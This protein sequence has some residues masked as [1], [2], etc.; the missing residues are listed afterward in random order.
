MAGPGA[1]DGPAGGTGPRGGR[2]D[3]PPV[4]FL[5]GPT[6]SGKSAL[7]L[8]LAEA[9][10]SEIVS[11]DSAQAYRGMDIGT[12]KPSLAERARVAHHLIDVVE[13]DDP[14]SA[15]RFVRDALARIGQIRARG[16]RPLLVGGTMLYFNALQHGLAPMPAADFALRAELAAEL[17]A[18][19]VAALHAE[20]ARVDPAAAARIHPHDPQRVQRALEVY[21]ASGTPLSE[22]QRRTRPALDE[23]VVKLALMPV[24]RAWL[25]A[26]IRA[27]FAAMLEAGLL[28]EVRALRSR[29]GV[30]A[31]LPSMRAVGYRQAWEHLDA[32]GGD[33]PGDDEWVGRAI[34]ATRQLAKRQLT[35]LRGMGDAGRLAPD[36]PDAGALLGG[37]LALVRDGERAGRGATATPT[38]RSDP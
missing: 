15:A 29:P 32:L 21:R 10:G 6:A 17:A 19:G 22:L 33:G 25:H 14:Y 1:E 20:L 7:S 24:E 34:A 31:G 30:H 8:P 36:G 28:D 5:I 16:R 26:R 27:R 3:H 23:P 37:A 12:A 13:P 38:K 2:S 9:L 11:V 18:R 35:W 4:V